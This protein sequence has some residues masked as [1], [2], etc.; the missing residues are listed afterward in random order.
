MPY[1]PNISID[2][3]FNIFEMKN[4]LFAIKDQ[5][6]ASEGINCFIAYN[7]LGA[8]AVDDPTLCFQYYQKALAIDKSNPTALN[9][10][11][12]YNFKNKNFIKYY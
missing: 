5:L 9:G 8:K 10:L 6:T 4:E 11:G 7:N 1:N 2:D 3:Y 12:G